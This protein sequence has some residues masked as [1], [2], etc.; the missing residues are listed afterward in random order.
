MKTIQEAV[1]ERGLTMDTAK[2]SLA[3]KPAET[4]VAIS[5]DAVVPEP[6]VSDVTP[7]SVET[8]NDDDIVSRVLSHKEE[9]KVEAPKPEGDPDFF[10]YADIEKITDPVAKEYAQKAYKSMERGVQKKFQEAAEMRKQLEQQ[11]T[12][13]GRWTPEKVQ[14]LLSNQEFIN[15]SQTVM[16]QANPTGGELSDDEWSAL[17]QSE[18]AEF[19]SMQSKILQMENQNRQMQMKQELE[20]QI[21]SLGTK[22]ASFNKDK[23]LSL[24][25]D[26]N[27]GKFNATL[28]HIHKVVDYEDAIRRAYRMGKED[29][30]L[31]VQEKVNVSTPVDSGTVAKTPT[32][33]V[34]QEG[35]SAK[36]FLKRRM[37]ARFAESQ[38]GKK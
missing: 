34:R 10:N 22:Y 8:N 9:P 24:L 27:A 33:V 36:E 12:E 4:Q 30:Q 14:S 6:V 28:E 17:S 2:A 29:R 11:L 13:S 25:S 5:A 37:L 1:A 19:K 38:S 35:E 16:Q 18:K 23:V 20:Q 32:E 31:D 7:N 15:A 21:S 26:V 3:P